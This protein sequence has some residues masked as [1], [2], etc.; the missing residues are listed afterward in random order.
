MTDIEKEFGF[1]LSKGNW[2]K[3]CNNKSCTHGYSKTM[4]QPRFKQIS[5]TA[6]LGFAGTE[7]KTSLEAADFDL[8][9]TIESVQSDLDD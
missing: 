6:D 1:S 7:K 4:N 9:M 5:N 3:C 8:D 2:S